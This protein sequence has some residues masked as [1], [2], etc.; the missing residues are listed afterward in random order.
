MV[1]CIST[2]RVWWRNLGE[3]VHAHDSM[4]RALRP[5]DALAYVS[6]YHRLE[7]R[8][9]ES[10]VARIGLGVPS[11]VIEPRLPGKL[12]H[13]GIGHVMVDVREPFGFRILRPHALR[14]AEIGD[15]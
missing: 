11:R 5:T 12:P 14:P 1:G 6:F 9:D 7:Q 2:S 8:R 15:A 10:P 4:I 3:D 13:L